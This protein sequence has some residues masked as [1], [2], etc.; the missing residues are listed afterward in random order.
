MSNNALL[1]YKCEIKVKYL[2]YFRYTYL[3]ETNFALGKKCDSHRNPHANYYIIS[4]IYCYKVILLHT[5]DFV[6]AR[7][8]MPD[9]QQH[10][11][12]IYHAEIIEEPVRAPCIILPRV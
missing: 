6:A 2:N 8:L 10:V 3:Y 7:T 12:S 9:H 5:F 4:R 11:L 1:K